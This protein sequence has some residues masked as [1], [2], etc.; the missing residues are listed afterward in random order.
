MAVRESGGEH[1]G[2]VPTRSSSGNHQKQGRD[3]DRMVSSPLFKRYSGICMN[4][5][6]RNLNS[7]RCDVYEQWPL[8]P[9]SR[10]DSEGLAAS[11]AAIHKVNLKP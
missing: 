9:T 10:D 4:C 6:A 1:A 8:T 5:S 11:V 2:C 7:F 3:H